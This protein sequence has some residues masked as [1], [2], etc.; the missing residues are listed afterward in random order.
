MLSSQSMH[1]RSALT[2]LKAQPRF[3]T[4]CCT[5]SN[6]IQKRFLQISTRPSTTLTPFQAHNPPD[7]PKLTRF[8][9]T[10]A[11]PLSTSPSSP[12]TLSSNSP[13]SSPTSTLSN[14]LTWNEYLALRKTRR[15]YNLVCSVFT[16]LLTTGSG[17]TL[18]GSTLTLEQINIFGLDPFMVAGLMTLGTGLVGYVHLNPMFPL[19]NLVMSNGTFLGSL[20]A[21]HVLLCPLRQA[22]LTSTHLQLGTGSIPRRSV[23]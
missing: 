15:R 8:E 12:S 4:Q 21:P 9:S 3:L 19:L 14:H 17:L 5:L 10:S 22:S 7:L 13:S 23:V 18:F 6:P 16:S 11:A 20:H 2:G 1:L